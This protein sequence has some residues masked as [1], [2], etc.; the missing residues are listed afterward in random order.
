M[1]DGKPNTVTV[2]VARLVQV[3]CDPNTEYVVVTVG[4]AVVFGVLVVVS[5][6]FGVQ[7]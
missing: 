1:I 2:I 7:V 5:A 3:D 6:V 4:F